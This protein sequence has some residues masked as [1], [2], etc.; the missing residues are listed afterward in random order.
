MR[1]IRPV[2]AGL[3]IALALGASAVG[4]TDATHRDAIRDYLIVKHCGFETDE[5][6][7]GFRIAV[8]ALIGEGKVSPS[9][10]RSDREAAAEEVRREWRNR[11]MGRA[12]P[13]CLTQGRAAFNHFLAVL[14]T[15]D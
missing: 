2:S 12:D 6:R 14:N 10:A 15:P 9:T 7:A 8:I 1:A 4:A 13:R 3:L 5:V 11:G